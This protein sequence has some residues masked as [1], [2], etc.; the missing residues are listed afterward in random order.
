VVRTITRPPTT[1][2]PKPPHKDQPKPGN[3]VR[4]TN[5]TPEHKPNDTLLDVFRFA[6]AVWGLP[7]ACTASDSLEEC[8]RKTPTKSICELMDRSFGL[9]PRGGCEPRM[10]PSEEAEAEFAIAV[11]TP[12]INPVSCPNAIAGLSIACAAT[13]AAAIDVFA[14]GRGPGGATGQKRGPVPWPNGPH[15]QKIWEIVRSLIER[16]YEHTKGGGSGA[17]EEVIQIA[18]GHKSARRPDATLVDPS[19]KEYRFN[20]GRTY[21]SGAPI[22]REVDAIEDLRRMGIDTDFF[23]YDR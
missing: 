3:G 11:Q 6:V 21:K 17:P 2:V 14:R 19:G 23:P 22:K 8:F 12:S 15:N 10:V 4:V 18:G 20:V 7:E 16:G 13:A 9:D 1:S 5:V